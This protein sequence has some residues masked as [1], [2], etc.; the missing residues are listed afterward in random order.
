MKRSK[1]KGLFT[2]P[3]TP[4]NETLRTD[5]M[6]RN[7]TITPRMTNQTFRVHRGNTF[8]NITIS[9]EMLGQK[10]GEFVR[11]RAVFEYKKKKKKKK[12]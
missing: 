7:N 6:H 10:F 12:N 9:S 2:K 8:K 3:R 5:I 11:T 1:W 4:K